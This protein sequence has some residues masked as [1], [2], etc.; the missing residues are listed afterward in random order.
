MTVEPFY[1]QLSA[2]LNAHGQ[3]VTATTWGDELRIAWRVWQNKYVPGPYIVPGMGTVPKVVSDWIAARMF[4]QGLADERAEHQ[5]VLAQRIL[6]RGRRVV[7]SYAYQ[8]KWLK[9]L[10]S[11]PENMVPPADPMRPGL[12]PMGG[13][14]V[15]FPEPTI[16]DLLPENRGKIIGIG[17]QNVIPN[18]LPSVPTSVRAVRVG[19]S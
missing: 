10:E 17:R 2:F 14:Q 19:V 6:A 16:E 3:T 1:S 15:F 8:R 18:E 12:G 13:A 11:L 4:D 5:A 7:A 9:L